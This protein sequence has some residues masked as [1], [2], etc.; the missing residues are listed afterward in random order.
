[1]KK[2]KRRFTSVMVW[3]F[4]RLG[5]RSALFLLFLGIY[6]TWRMNEEMHLGLDMRIRPIVLGIIWIVFMVEMMLRLFPSRFESPG[7][8]KQFYRN[9]VPAEQIQD[10][11]VPVEQ[12]SAEQKPDEKAQAKQ[13]PVVRGKIDIPD[14]NATMLVA[15]MWVGL[16][17]IFGALYMAHILDDGI[18][19][20]LACAFAVCD[21]IC[22][23][24]FCPFQTWFLKNKCCG[25]CRI[26]NW[27]YAMMFTPLFFV[28]TPYTWSLFFMSILLLLRWEIVFYLHPERFSEKSNAYLACE[29]CTEKLCGY[30]TQLHSLWKKM[31]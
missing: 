25:S 16:N 28:K 10:G 30:K 6:V 1:M 24:F 5:Y 9:F 12:M 29:N 8:Q 18:M 19:I 21:M 4:I 15:F 2:H 23:L 31:I 22:I 17:L 13:V 14:N 11:P 3:H 20:L 7:S 26:Y 27:D